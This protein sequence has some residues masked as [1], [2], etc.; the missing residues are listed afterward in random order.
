MLR[1]YL[2]KLTSTVATTANDATKASVRDPLE[3]SL[4]YKLRRDALEITA[5]MPGDGKG[6]S[7]D[8]RSKRLL[9]VQSRLIEAMCSDPS[10]SDRQR[11][12]LMTFHSK[13]V[14][15]LIADRRGAR[16]RT[17][18]ARIAA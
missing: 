11:S 15:D 17:N 9:W 1:Q 13:A 7:A 8:A 14:R 2:R 4:C 5:R 6:L 18:L 12:V 16:L 10:L 3:F